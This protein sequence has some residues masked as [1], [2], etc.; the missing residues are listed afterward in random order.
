LKCRLNGADDVPAQFV[1]STLVICN[2]PGKAKPV[3]TKIEVT[4]N[5][6]VVS[7]NS[8][9]VTFINEPRITALNVSFYYYNVKERVPVLVTG[10]YLDSNRLDGGTIYVKVAHGVSVWKIG[11]GSSTFVFQ[12]P[13]GLD[14]GLYPITVSTDG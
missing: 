13:L 10:Q 12:M 4:M 2:I 3:T 9:T 11:A 7:I 8:L 1:N 5:D 14:F 6:N